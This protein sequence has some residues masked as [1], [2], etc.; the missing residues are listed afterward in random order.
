MDLIKMNVLVKEL[1]GLKDMFPTKYDVYDECMSSL[2]KEFGEENIFYVVEEML[3]HLDNYINSNP[4]I[5][6]E[7]EFHEIVH[8]VL[9]EYFEGISQFEN[10]YD[11]DLEATALC[12]YCESLY[13][14]HI[15]PERECEGTFI[16]KLPN[17][18]IVAKKINYLKNKPQPNQRTSEWYKFRHNLITASN[19]WKAF[20]SQSC[21]NQLIY[22]KCK[23]FCEKEQYISVN[24]NSSLHWGQKY[25]PVSRMV[26]EHLYHTRVSDF[27]CIIH[28]KHEFIGASPDGINVD[29]NSMRYGRML[30]I[31]NI[32]NREITGIPKKEYWI[33]MQMQMEVFNL[34]EC[35]FFE[36]YFVEDGTEEIEE[37]MKETEEPLMQG[38][39][40]FFMNNGTPHYEYEPLGLNSTDAEKWL[41]VVMERNKD[42]V[43]IKN[44]N[45]RLKKMS[46]VL[47]LRNTRWFESAIK[48]LANV[49][50]TI[51]KEREFPEVY[52]MRAPKKRSSSSQDCLTKLI[53]DWLNAENRCLIE[54]IEY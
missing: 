3:N 44:I 52:N 33:Q 46:C 19:A 11:M 12:Y 9:Y 39:I 20:G 31:K 37:E 51:V 41:N 35:D 43:W 14:R 25:E 17:M 15:V 2:F 38:M 24:T 23:P 8:D 7:P 45:W 34:N 26:Y 30:E 1:H 42:K 21:V 13:F 4:L 10:S 50:E 48:I 6:S 40:L 28:D 16:R 5:F 32:I 27:G 54:N 53:S 18:D 47:V 36:T 49:W 22:E 29:P